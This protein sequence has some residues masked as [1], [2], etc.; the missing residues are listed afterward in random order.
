M[1]TSEHMATFNALTRT[2]AQ[3]ARVIDMR[4]RKLQRLQVCAIVH[5]YQAKRIP[6]FLRPGP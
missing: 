5:Q 6:A 2:D 3:A 4:M 1:Q